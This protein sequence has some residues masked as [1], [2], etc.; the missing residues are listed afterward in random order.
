[1]SIASR[2]PATGVGWTS[3][4]HPMDQ[5]EP[6]TMGGPCNSSKTGNCSIRMG[7]ASLYK[8]AHGEGPMHFRRLA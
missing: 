4:L 1:M 8:S 3:R 6:P 2:L 5:L 7:R